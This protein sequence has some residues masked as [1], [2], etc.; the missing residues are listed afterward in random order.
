VQNEI[1]KVKVEKSIS[2]REAKEIV[3][4]RAGLNSVNQMTYSNKVSGNK[5]VN[6]AKVSCSSVMTVSCQTDLTWPLTSKVPQLYTTPDNTNASSQFS[7]T[8]QY[9]QSLVASA[10]SKSSINTPSVLPDQT[11]I[12]AI[13]TGTS[14]PSCSTS[15]SKPQLS[16]GSRI[17][18]TNLDRKGAPDGH[19]QR[20][21]SGATKTDNKFSVLQDAE[22]D[23]HEDLGTKSKSVKV[24]PP[25]KITAKK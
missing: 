8:P 21:S 11:S 22:M 24:K 17:I 3:E 12:N 7:Q 16:Q 1:T 10:S 15:L 9:D 2:F 13:I 14:Q 25:D 19:I 6:N 20:G 23:V 4:R 5:H 18:R